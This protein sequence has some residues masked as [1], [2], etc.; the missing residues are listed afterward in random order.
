MADAEDFGSQQGETACLDS[1]P[2][3]IQQRSRF[4]M[5]NPLSYDCSSK[6]ITS[7]SRESIKSKTA[8]KDNKRSECIASP[9]GDTVQQTGSGATR[10]NSTDGD[11]VQQTDSGAT[12]IN[13][14]DGH[15]ADTRFAAKHSHDDRED[16]EEEMSSED[17][18]DEGKV[19][20]AQQTGLSGLSDMPIPFCEKGDDDQKNSTIH[21]HDSN[22]QETSLC[23]EPSAK[24]N[25]VLYNEDSSAIQ[26]EMHQT[27]NPKNLPYVCDQCGK[28]F[29]EKGHLKYHT[30]THSDEKQFTCDICNRGF[31]FSFNLTKHRRTHTGEKPYS[32]N[33]C[34][35]KFSHKN[36][37]NRHVTLHTG[38]S[39]QKCKIC[40]KD[41]YDKQSLRKHLITHTTD[42]ENKCQTCNREFN[43]KR[44]FLIH[45]QSHVSA[46]EASIVNKT[47]AFECDICHRSYTLKSSL[48]RHMKKHDNVYN[49]D[50]KSDDESVDSTIGIDSDLNDSWNIAQ[51]QKIYFQDQ[52][53]INNLMDQTTDA[54]HKKDFFQPGISL[55]KR[56]H[57]ESGL[58]DSKL[59]LDSCIDQGMNLSMKSGTY[60]NHQ[61]ATASPEG[62]RHISDEERSGCFMDETA[63][64]LSMKTC[65]VA[66]D[67]SIKQ[68]PVEDVS[69]YSRNT[70]NEDVDT[71]VDSDC[72]LDLSTNKFNMQMSENMS[73][74]ALPQ[75]IEPEE[76]EYHESTI[77]MKM[78]CEPQERTLKCKKCPMTF[79]DRLHLLYHSKEYH[80]ESLS[81]SPVDMMHLGFGENA[82]QTSQ[83]ADEMED[84]MESSKCP[85]CGDEFSSTSALNKHL[86]I[87]FKDKTDFC[88][89]CYR[90]FAEKDIFKAH[91]QTHTDQVYECSICPRT[92]DLKIEQ[93][94]HIKE[95]KEGKPFVCGQCEKSFPIKY[96]LESHMR[97]H[98]GDKPFK[99]QTCGRGF[100]HSFNLTKHVRIHTGERPYECPQCQRKFAQKNSLNR[101]MYLHVGQSPFKCKFCDKFFAHNFALQIHMS[102]IH[103]IYDNEYTQDD[104]EE[105]LTSLQNEKLQTSV[106]KT[107]LY[108]D[109]HAHSEEVR[110]T[111]RICVDKSMSS[112][113]FQDFN[114]YSPNITTKEHLYEKQHDEKADVSNESEDQSDNPEEP[115]SKFNEATYSQSHKYVEEMQ[116][117]EGKRNMEHF[118]AGNTFMPWQMPK[119]LGLP[120][121]QLP[122]MPMMDPSMV[123]S[124]Y[125][126]NSYIEAQ[127]FGFMRSMQEN[128]G[129]EVPFNEK[130]PTPSRPLVTEKVA[131]F[132]EVVDVQNRNVDKSEQT[133]ES[134]MHVCQECGKS[135]KKKY[136]LKSHMRVHTGE[137]PFKCEICG[138]TFSYSFNMKKHIR[139]HTGEQPYQCQICKRR[140]SHINSL[141]RHASTHT[142]TS[143]RCSCRY[144]LCDATFSDKNSLYQHVLLKHGL[145]RELMNPSE[146]RCNDSNI[147]HLPTDVPFNNN[148]DSSLTLANT[149]PG[150]M[151]HI[152]GDVNVTP[153]DSAM[154]NAP[155]KNNITNEARKEDEE[156]METHDLSYEEYDG[157]DSTSQVCN[158]SVGSSIGQENVFNVNGGSYHQ[159]N[160]QSAHLVD[161]LID[162]KYEFNPNDVVQN[163]SKPKRGRKSSGPSVSLVCHVCA[164]VFLKK[165]DLKSHLKVHSD[166]RPFNCDLCPKA[167]NHKSTLTNHRRIH[168]GEK[169]YGCEICKKGFTFLSSLQRHKLLH[170]TET[171]FKCFV[172]GENQEDK[173]TL[174]KHL[175]THV[176]GGEVHR[177]NQIA[178]TI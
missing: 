112:E 14:T 11:T 169:P 54:S 94:D 23:Q 52:F 126:L 36:S 28:G 143:S 51:S 67:F 59:I 39:H 41:F 88:E 168:T 167:F 15:E 77:G 171:T 104:F 57:R 159:A 74:Q 79:D 70:W 81:P 98:F 43:D 161:P 37:L 144:P 82:S 162:D 175:K 105:H 114:G 133:P 107:L 120:P 131:R 163:P 137:K 177:G 85:Y 129:L 2:S 130:I 155:D 160:G 83:S 173:Q 178:A 90:M 7:F 63:L 16:S 158:L 148:A 48:N 40:D 101:H 139:T 136:Y 26:P 50:F 3:S 145:H 118:N 12:R 117:Y 125:L 128:E 24:G 146:S 33:F 20:S 65:S 71:Q 170:M 75:K 60:I 172:C 44:G 1:N 132:R 153:H 102:K 123:M 99:C 110:S 27:A 78:S 55:Y 4:D 151:V 165:Q 9:D 103:G 106:T 10:I 32:C 176:Q 174:N 91:I 8:E 69:N 76:I 96:Y 116:H 157:D 73:R 140:F 150:G 100:T 164:K 89:F 115:L 119:G 122:T 42:G 62:M 95:H 64:D 31:H 109:T 142:D 72:A 147:E 113:G 53:R 92:F 152:Q 66:L 22:C 38:F 13:S 80:Q 46:F 61:P 166:A 30:R 124:A 149:N 138:K 111:K 56:E 5:E 108:N 156:D 35:K 45:M 49:Q 6:S 18:M 17:E 29:H 97:V 47:P 19:L 84:V 68:E 135:F 21:E 154:T 58:S 141:N 134:D 127:Q 93:Q 87:H 25:S 34:G 86:L 121:F